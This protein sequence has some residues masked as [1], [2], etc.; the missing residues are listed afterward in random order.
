[1]DRVQS[2]QLG[3]R[4]GYI[5]DI[6]YSLVDD[7][8]LSRN[9][10]ASDC[11]HEQL[12]QKCQGDHWDGHSG[13]DG[14]LIEKNIIRSVQIST[15]IEEGPMKVY[16]YAKKCLEGFYGAGASVVFSTGKSQV[17]IFKGKENNTTF[18]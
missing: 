15:A 11:R 14:E 3:G 2:W 18:Q 12:A 17:G 5:Q 13:R 1:M 4:L 8:S 9:V 16:L 6:E 7:L 10:T